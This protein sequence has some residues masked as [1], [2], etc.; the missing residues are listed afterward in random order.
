MITFTDLSGPLLLDVDQVEHYKMTFIV[1]LA[2]RAKVLSSALHFTCTAAGADGQ[3]GRIDRAGEHEQVKAASK[4]SCKAN[5]RTEHIMSSLIFQAS[6]AGYALRVSHQAQAR[7]FSL[8]GAFARSF[9][10]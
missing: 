4:A 7:S 8:R 10:E 9:D 6:T 1:S 3:P 5:L 2:Q